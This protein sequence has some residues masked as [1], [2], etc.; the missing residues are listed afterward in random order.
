MTI[1]ITESLV[2]L[3]LTEAKK[4][5]NKA[6]EEFYSKHGKVDFGTCGFATIAGLCGRKRKVRGLLEENG[7]NV[8]NWGGRHKY[9]LDIKT[10][11]PIS[12]QNIDIRIAVAKAQ[13]NVLNEYLGLELFVHSW[14]D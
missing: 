5:G 9:T 7:V 12:T 2:T 13:A 4:A 1:K 8:D 10:N 11:V 14:V 3:A 6:I